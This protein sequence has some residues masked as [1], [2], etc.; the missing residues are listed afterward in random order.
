[1]V[2]ISVFICL[3]SHF[4]KVLICK[5][6]FSYFKL[7]YL[8]NILNLK[9]KEKNLAKQNLYL[10]DMGLPTK[11]SVDRH[12]TVS[13][14]ID[15]SKLFSRIGVL[16]PP[17]SGK[18]A[19]AQLVKQSLEQKGETAHILTCNDFEEFCNCFRFECGPEYKRN[20]IFSHYFEANIG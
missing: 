6:L 2:S 16:S 5:L 12:E 1:M 9:L 18:S 19:L 3:L 10:T 11:F 20:Y 14:L 8:L 4:L 7:I 17:F 13:K 15:A